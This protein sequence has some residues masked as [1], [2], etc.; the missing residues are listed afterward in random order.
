MEDKD[1]YHEIDNNIQ[2]LLQ[3]ILGDSFEV[4]KTGTINP[5]FYKGHMEFGDMGGLQI[6]IC[7]KDYEHHPTYEQIQNHFKSIA[8]QYKEN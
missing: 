7:L 3:M 5:D 1:L 8:K 2:D 6:T 4:W